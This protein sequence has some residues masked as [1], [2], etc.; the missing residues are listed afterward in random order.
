M[1]YDDY[2]LELV[3]VLES[4]SF[5]TYRGKLEKANEQFAERLAT[6]LRKY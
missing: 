2:L 4:Y 5:I 6:R 3:A 1:H